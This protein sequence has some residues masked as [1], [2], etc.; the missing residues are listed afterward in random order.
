KRQLD[1]NNAIST[2]SYTAD[3]IAY[4]REYFVSAPQQ[5]MV[6]HVTAGKP[7]AISVQAVLNTPHKKYTVRK[8]DDH[9]LALSLQV[10]DGVLKGVSYLHVNTNGGACTINDTAITIQKAGEVTFYLVAATSYKNYND[11]SANPALLCAQ[12]LQAIK[13][14]TYSSIKEAHIKEY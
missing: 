12:A 1:I 11:V 10:T 9:T 13:G 4:T 14:K 5:C 3:D 7:G 6:M 2:V 8:I